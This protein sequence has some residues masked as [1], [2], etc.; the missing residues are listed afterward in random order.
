MTER[1]ELVKA[2]IEGYTSGE[3]KLTGLE[4]ALLVLCAFLFGMLLGIYLSPKH[5][6]RV[7]IGSNNGNHN[8][9]GN[10]G[11]LPFD[12]DDDEFAD[13]EDFE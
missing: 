4:C 13:W 7:Q 9:S 1:L 3:E 5:Q 12:D 10:T 2:W 6:K 11:C 8:G